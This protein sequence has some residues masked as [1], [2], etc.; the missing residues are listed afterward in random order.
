METFINP[1]NGNHRWT[2]MNLRLH[3]IPDLL[4]NHIFDKMII[5]LQDTYT[6]KKKAEMKHQEKVIKPNKKK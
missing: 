4:T 2:K 3:Q 5:S 6:K 1:G